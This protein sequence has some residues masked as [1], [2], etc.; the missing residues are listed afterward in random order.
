MNDNTDLLGDHD[1]FT[2]YE[3]TYYDAGGY[4]DHCNYYEDEDLFSIGRD[5]ASGETYSNFSLC[6]NPSGGLRIDYPSEKAL[7]NTFKIEISEL[8]YYWGF[9]RHES[10]KNTYWQFDPKLEINITVSDENLGANS[11]A[12]YFACCKTELDAEI[13]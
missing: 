8:T 7:N 5:M 6:Y 4:D 13:A 9:S 12:D 1:G 3:G 11:S 2:E 10:S